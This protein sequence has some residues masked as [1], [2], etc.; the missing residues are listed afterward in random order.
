[1]KPPLYNDSRKFDVWRIFNF[2]SILKSQFLFYS[3][4]QEIATFIFIFVWYSEFNMLGRGNRT[5]FVLEKKASIFKPIVVSFVTKNFPH[6]MTIYDTYE[7]KKDL[8]FLIYC[9][10]SKTSQD[11]MRTLGKCRLQTWKWQQVHYC[12]NIFCKIATV[13]IFNI[14]NIVSHYELQLY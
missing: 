3:K 11:K 10:V 14:P 6:T 4:I 12:T 5:G 2:H 1:M 7:K 8:R 9:T 13:S